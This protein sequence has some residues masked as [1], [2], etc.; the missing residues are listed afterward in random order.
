MVKHF[1]LVTSQVMSDSLKL[2]I[3]EKLSGRNISTC[4]F[5]CVWNK[6]LLT[7]KL[8]FILLK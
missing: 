2:E 6:R 1:K 7:E 8:I 3:T 5:K 4:I